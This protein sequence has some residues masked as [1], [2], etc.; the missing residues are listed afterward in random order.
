MTHKPRVV[1]WMQQSDLDPVAD[2][3]FLGHI[4]LC[5]PTPNSIE[6]SRRDSINLFCQRGGRKLI[7]TRSLIHKAHKLEASLI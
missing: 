2:D 4:P 3:T 1:C 7:K 5:Y 6:D